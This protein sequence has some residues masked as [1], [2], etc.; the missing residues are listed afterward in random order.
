MSTKEKIVNI[1]KQLEPFL[2]FVANH[3]AIQK[4]S[5]AAAAMVADIFRNIETIRDSR[6]WSVSFSLFNKEVDT[7]NSTN[8]IFRYDWHVSMENGSFS[9]EAKRR[10]YPYPQ[11]NEYVFMLN[12]DFKTG[13]FINAENKEVA[14]FLKDVFNYQQYI[15]QDITETE[16]EIEIT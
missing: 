11:D 4:E 10:Y 1:I 6:N 15:T 5:S 14:V 16:A 3:P 7:S 2:A 13:Y 12:Y 9:V 8:R